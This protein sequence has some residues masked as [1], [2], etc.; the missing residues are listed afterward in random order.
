MTKKPTRLEPAVLI[1]AALAVFVVLGIL[2]GGIYLIYREYRQATVYRSVDGRVLSSE[3][4]TRHIQ[5]AKIRPAAFTPK[6]RYKYQV[7]GQDYEGSRIRMYKENSS[8][9]KAMARMQE[10]YPE[11]SRVKVYYDPDDPSTAVLEPGF[12]AISFAILLVG[13]F[14]V[15]LAAFLLLKCRQ[16]SIKGSVLQ[17]YN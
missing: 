15:L 2:G 5:S 10:R 1:G 4:A 16:G 17:N 11:G 12:T 9:K 8:N 13:F 7:D 14:G 6:V 3:L